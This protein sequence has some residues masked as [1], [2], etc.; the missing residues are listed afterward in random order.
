M[1]NLNDEKDHINRSE[2]KWI[3]LGVLAAICALVG[4]AEP[5]LQNGVSVSAALSTRGDQTVLVAPNLK[6]HGHVNQGSGYRESALLEAFWFR[7]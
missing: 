2:F 5:K 1:I 3:A 6:R 7:L 4:F